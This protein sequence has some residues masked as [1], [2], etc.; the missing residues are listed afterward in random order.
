MRFTTK[1]HAGVFEGLEIPLGLGLFSTANDTLAVIHF[2]LDQGIRVL[3]TTEVDCLVEDD[4]HDG[5]RLARQALDS[6]H[7]P[8][9]EVKVLTKVGLTR[10]GR[11]WVP[12]GQPEHQRRSVDESLL[13]LGVDRLFLLQL[14]ARDPRVPFEETLAALAELQRSGKVEHVGLCNVTPGEL[15]QAQKHFQVATVQNEL[16]V[17]NRKSAANGLLTLT[18]E[19]GIVFLASYPFGAKASRLAKD[20]ILIPLSQR[21]QASSQEMALAALLDT[22]PHV[23]PIIRATSIDNIRSCLAATRLSLDVSDRTALAL[24]MSFDPDPEALAAAR[25][26]FVKDEPPKEEE[27]PRKRSNTAACP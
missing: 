19:H 11:R 23:V 22:G 6:W 10:S 2:A 26:L 12:G 5:E 17:L 15:D 27:E 8:K 25:Q 4:L 1:R 13:A 14:H 24:G 16:S 20:R 21:H 3:D 9:N 18:Q 7:G